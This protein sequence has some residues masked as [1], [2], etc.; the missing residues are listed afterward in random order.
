[1]RQILFILLL[2]ISHFSLAQSLVVYTENL[3]PYQFKD[4]K[5]QVTGYS[6]ELV[7]GMLKEADIDAKITIVPW[8][9]GYNAALK[10]KNV[11]LFSMVRTA[12]RE[13]LFEWIGEVDR[14]NYYLFKLSARKDIKIASLTQATQYRVGAGSTSFEYEK[15]KQLG[16]PRVL[17]NPNYSQLIKMLES[18]RFDLFF[19]SDEAFKGM[20]TRAKRP[21][22]LFDVAYKMTQINQGMYIAMSRSSDPVL[23]KRLQQAYV[24]V[25]SPAYREKLKKK[26]FTQ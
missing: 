7:R 26:W 17:G 15:L 8:V 21:K 2:T 23:V 9:R 6:V 16:F 18:N 20:L 24:R 25:I 5:Q 1:M 11:M 14:M 12:E 3:P 13:E 19:T 4:H 22:S 10:T